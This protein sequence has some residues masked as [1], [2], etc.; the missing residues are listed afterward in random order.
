MTV[1]A[2]TG[3]ASGRTPAAGV[4]RGT[5]TDNSCFEGRGLTSKL[6]RLFHLLLVIVATLGQPGNWAIFPRDVITNVKFTTQGNRLELDV[7]GAVRVD[8]SDTDSIPIIP[9][10]AF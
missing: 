9:S 1:P 8:E 5:M 3:R 4:F 10:A 2:L 7:D 6:C